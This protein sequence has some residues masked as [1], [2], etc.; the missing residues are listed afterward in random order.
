MMPTKRICSMAALLAAALLAGCAETPIIGGG[1]EPAKPHPRADAVTP[2]ARV[3]AAVSPVAVA[4]DPDKAALRDGIDAY[5]NGDYNGAIKKLSVPEIVKGPK[6]TQLSA[7]KYTAF[8][9]C[10]SNRPT[11]CRQ[12]FDKALK[13]DPA[14]ELDTGENGHPLWGP[15]FARAKKGK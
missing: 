3:D 10:V 6:A 15:V 1:K 4:V 12:T 5:N 2:H 13:L 11:Q 7:L 14:F 9:Y 8:S